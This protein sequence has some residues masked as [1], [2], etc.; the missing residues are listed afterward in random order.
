MPLEEKVRNEYKSLT[1][2]LPTFEYSYVQ[3]KLAEAIGHFLNYY[4]GP[5]PSQ[6]L[7]FFAVALTAGVL[8]E[9]L[10]KT[11]EG[12]IYFSLEEVVKAFR[13]LYTDS[14]LSDVLDKPSKKIR[15]GVMN[16]LEKIKEL[17][18]GKLRIGSSDSVILSE[19]LPKALGYVKLEQGGEF[20]QLCA[21]NSRFN[22]VNGFRFVL[23]KRADPDYTDIK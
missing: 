14:K 7:R 11:D 21:K 17:E 4:K 3:D 20:F 18:S 23:P 1:N 12:I 22:P 13:G 9:K 6:R 16:A 15:E 5:V 10:E 19:Y 2:G 8:S